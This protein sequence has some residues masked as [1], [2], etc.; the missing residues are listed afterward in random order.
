MHCLYLVLKERSE[1]A[2]EDE[3]AVAQ[4]RKPLDPTKASEYLQQLKTA[5]ANITQM[6][7][8]QSQ[9]AAVSLHIWFKNYCSLKPL[10]ERELG[11]GKIW[12]VAC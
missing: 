10:S 6:F 12:T 3:I 5:S 4:G 8:K 1:G 2:N 9:R 11:P 7:A